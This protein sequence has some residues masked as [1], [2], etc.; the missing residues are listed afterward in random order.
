M[1][2]SG[3]HREAG[4]L[5][6]AGHELVTTEEEEL[7]L[8]GTVES[9]TGTGECKRAVVLVLLDT[10]RSMSDLDEEIRE[11]F[12]LENRISVMRGLLANVVEELTED[13][14]FGLVTFNNRGNVIIPCDYANE[15]NRSVWKCLMEDDELFKCKGRTNMERGINAAVDELDR[16]RQDENL[17]NSSVIIL[18]DGEVSSGAGFVN[19]G[20]PDDSGRAIRE[21]RRAVE[22]KL[23]ESDELD[24]CINA[25]LVGDSIESSLMREVTEKCGN[26]GQMRI[27]SRASSKVV[28]STSF[29]YS[30]IQNAR[31]TIQTDQRK[32]ITITA[33]DGVT[34]TPKAPFSKAGADAG[35]LGRG[36]LICKEIERGRV[37]EVHVARQNE[38]T[39]SKFNFS[40]SLDE[41][42]SDTD[43]FKVAKV[44]CNVWPQNRPPHLITVKRHFHSTP[45]PRPSIVAQSVACEKKH[46]VVRYLE[47]PKDA[48]AANQFRQIL[49]VL[50]T[51]LHDLKSIREEFESD[52]DPDIEHYGTLVSESLR[53][54]AS[55]L[56]IELPTEKSKAFD[57]RFVDKLTTERYYLLK[58]Q[59]KEELDKVAELQRVQGFEGLSTSNEASAYQH[60][61]MEEL[62]RLF[63]ADT[64]PDA[65]SEDFASENDGSDGS[66]GGDDNDDDGGGESNDDSGKRDNK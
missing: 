22:T 28:N 39:T 34:I 58:N 13:D 49:N 12:H 6:Q 14:V 33:L 60:A 40:A 44:N 8:L 38:E 29:M 59:M 32:I 43:A 21:L 42:E 54:F 23:E 18:G 41:I 52:E 64:H 10:S 2:S 36:P 50:D 11:T 62:D 3:E 55:T 7:R 30:L 56:R 26:S 53:S 20:D 25:C 15:E 17:R 5:V 63:Y 9:P 31:H 45:Q 57:P 16:I 61:L 37:Y 51:A 48:E 24:V 4:I 46:E 27:C 19:S 47:N 35:T 66:D 65:D 1:P